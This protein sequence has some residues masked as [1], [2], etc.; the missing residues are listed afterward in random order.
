MELITFIPA[1]MQIHF[2]SS[3]YGG[4]FNFASLFAKTL[5]DGKLLLMRDKRCRLCVAMV[6]L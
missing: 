3:N 5:R 6:I 2:A 1:L 4:E